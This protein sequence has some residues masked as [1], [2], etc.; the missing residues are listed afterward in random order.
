[1]HIWQYKNVGQNSLDP[2]FKKLILNPIEKNSKMSSEILLRD[3]I[4]KRSILIKDPGKIAEGFNRTTAG[5]SKNKEDQL[6]QGTDKGELE[7]YEET[8]S[9]PMRSSQSAPRLG[10]LDSH[11]KSMLLLLLI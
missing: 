5:S 3:P 8:K 6:E 1:M 10:Q 7:N 11:P 4:F 9:K 2:N